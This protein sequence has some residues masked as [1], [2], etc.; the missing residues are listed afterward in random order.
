MTRDPWGVSCEHHDDDARPAWLWLSNARPANRSTAAAPKPKGGKCGRKPR[1]DFPAGMVSVY[2]AAR[3][4]GVQFWALYAAK[5]AGRIG[6]EKDPLG[7]L[8][9]VADVERFVREK[10]QRRKRRSA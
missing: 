1:T 2:E 4:Y 6:W 10:G 8:L 5:K 7:V 3:R 9:V